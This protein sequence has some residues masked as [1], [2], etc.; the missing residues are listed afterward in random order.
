MTDIVFRLRMVD[1][2]QVLLMEP[3]F[4]TRYLHA[5]LL[6]HEAANEIERLRAEQLPTPPEE[7]QTE[8]EKKACA[9]GYWAGVAAI[10]ATGEKP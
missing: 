6:C 10:R 2:N 1:P 5:G 3:P 9:F 7:C 4:D 8:A